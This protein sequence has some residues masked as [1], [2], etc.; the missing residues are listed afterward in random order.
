MKLQVEPE[1]VTDRWGYWMPPS[2]KVWKLFHLHPDPETTLSN[3]GFI[4]NGSCDVCGERPPDSLI[5]LVQAKN[6]MSK[7]TI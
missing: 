6:N 5:K 2:D 1:L 4:K 3:P 7:V